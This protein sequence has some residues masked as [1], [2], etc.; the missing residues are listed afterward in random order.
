MDSQ[1]I[2]NLLMQYLDGSLPPGQRAAV[3]KIIESDPEAK[4]QF[5]AYQTLDELLR[6]ESPM[7]SILW[8]KLAKR[9]SATIKS[10]K[11]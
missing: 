7:P 11:A 3:R 8:E 5:D 4:A 1:E 6:S 10:R 9:I 2:D